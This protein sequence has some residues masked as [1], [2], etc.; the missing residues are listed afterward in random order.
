M[1]KTTELPNM[2]VFRRNNSN[3][4]VIRFGSNNEMPIKKLEILKKLFKSQKLI[5]LKNVVKKLEF[6]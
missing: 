2:L 4:I 3:N 6:I 5:K 1:L